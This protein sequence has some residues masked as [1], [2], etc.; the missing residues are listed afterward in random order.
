[1]ARPVDYTGGR[2]CRIAISPGPPRPTRERPG[3]RAM[4]HASMLA[5]IGDRRCLGFPRQNS[6]SRL[7]PLV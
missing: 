1:M 3:L 7:S 4:W 5:R 2:L 6:H